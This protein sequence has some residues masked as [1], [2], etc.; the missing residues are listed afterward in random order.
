[1]WAQGLNSPRGMARAANNDLLVVEQSSQQV[2]GTQLAF[3]FFIFIFI[4][5]F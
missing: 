2:T 5:I 3:D 4:F 1:V